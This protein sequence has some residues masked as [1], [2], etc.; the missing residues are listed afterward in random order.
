MEQQMKRYTKI[1]AMA[2]FS[3]V[4]DMPS[5]LAAGNDNAPNV[6]FGTLIAQIDEVN[7]VLEHIMR[8]LESL[9]GRQRSQVEFSGRSS[10]QPGGEALAEP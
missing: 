6:D 8:T 1:A 7:D 2:K 3:S 10:P 9:K 5:M 4:G